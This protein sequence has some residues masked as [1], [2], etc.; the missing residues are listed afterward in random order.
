[1][2]LRRN[3]REVNGE[4]YE[5]W[6]LVESYRTERGPRQRVVATLGKLGGLDQEER[7]GWEELEWLLEGQRPPRQL[8]LGSEEQTLGVTGPL[9]AEVDLSGVRVER[10]RDFGEVYLA[11]SLWRRLGLDELLA[12]LIEAGSEAVEWEQVACLLTL[13][14]FSAQ[15]S[16]PCAFWQWYIQLQQAEAAFRTGKSDLWLRPMFHQKTERVEAH[17][18]PHPGL[19]FGTGAVAN[20]GDVD[21][22][23]RPGHLRPPTF[24]R[25][26][27]GAQHGR[28][29][30]AQ[31]PRRSP[32]A[33]RRQTRPPRSGAPPPVGSDPAARAENR[34][35]CSGENHPL[36]G[37]SPC[38]S[39]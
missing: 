27:H 18:S 1:M 2:F 15:K 30:A 6:T 26:R 32:A 8:K 29:P 35:K 3:R 24:Q 4:T 39:D 31:K 11:L 19:L 23:Q 5:Y 34:R 25:S 33:R 21:A 22:R 28:D 10:V 37:V 13:A 36:I 20:P 16:D 9:W 7:H 12:G 17:I 14:R 38:K